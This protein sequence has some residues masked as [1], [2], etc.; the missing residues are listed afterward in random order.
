[1]EFTIR[2]IDQHDIPFLWEMLYQ[3]LYVPEGEKPFPREILQKP[4]ISKYASDWGRHGDI[5]LI[6]KTQDR[7]P[8]G[9]VWLRLFD[10]TNKGYGY[11]DDNTPELWISVA[12]GCRGQGIGNALM[13]EIEM[14]A[15][16]FGYQKLSLS[17]DPHNP[18]RR[19]Y[20]RLGY[21]QV[22]WCDTS[23]TMKKNLA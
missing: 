20:E 4:H 2:D 22:G 10:G 11:V 13:R 8:L 16:E 18:A 5:A 9:V 17:V 3:S 19:L 6:A 21:V 15:K 14:R 1:M 12:E 23:W 7:E